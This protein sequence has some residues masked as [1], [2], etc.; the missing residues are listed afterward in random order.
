MNI[1]WSKQ[2]MRVSRTEIK[3]A[4]ERLQ[5]LSEPLTKLSKKTTGKFTCQRV[6]FGRIKAFDRDRQSYRQKP[7]NQ[8][9]GQTHH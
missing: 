8:T 5:A 9:C 3:K 7:P 2:D 4:H 1:D 6:F